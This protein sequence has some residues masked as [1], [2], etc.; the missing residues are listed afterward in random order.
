MA[1]GSL[2]LKNGEQKIEGKWHILC[3]V[4]GTL[5]QEGVQ[6]KDSQ[7]YGHETKPSGL[8]PPLSVVP[9]CVSHVC[10]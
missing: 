10:T 2:T 7:C 4:R 3:E 5:K 1:L 8:A 6:C 9:Q